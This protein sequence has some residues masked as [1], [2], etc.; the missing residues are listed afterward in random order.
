MLNNLFKTQEQALPDPAKNAREKPIRVLHVAFTMNARGTETWLMHVLRNIDR[1]QI[2]MDFLTIEGERG[3]YDLEITELGGRLLPCKHPDNKFSFLLS[4]YKTLKAKGPYD[5]VHAH[6]HTLSGLIVLVAALAGV[7]ARI[8]HAHSDQSRV[9]DRVSK[10]RK[11]YTKMMQKLIRNF[12]TSGIAVSEN[13]AD[14]L[15]GEEWFTD[16]R[17]QVMHC[18]IDLDVFDIATEKNMRREF[19]FSE[20]DFVIGHVG[21]LNP[22]KNHFFLLEAFSSVLKKLPQVKLLLVGDGPLY[23]DIREKSDELGISQN[24]V[25]TGVRQ[26]VPQILKNGVDLFVFPSEYEGLGLSVIEAQA[27]GLPCIISDR[28]PDEAILLQKNVQKLALEDGPDLWA[29][30]IASR[31]KERKPHPE[32]AFEKVRESDFNIH[33]NI[34]ALTALYFQLVEQE[35]EK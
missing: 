7:K 11:F 20:N 18:G 33:Q 32:I 21:G 9:A 17:W 8:V 28:V 4:L 1:N 29:K 16:S 15:F 31:L 34:Y 27:A 13:A 25:M 12:A 26:D 10:L 14:F 6:P 35:E 19:G 5:I 3:V 23:D 2:H 30:K 22:E 24:I